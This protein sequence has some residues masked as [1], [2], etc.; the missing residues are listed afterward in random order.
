MKNLTLILILLFY[1][2]PAL[3]AQ[4][5][6][7][8]NFQKNRLTDSIVK[9]DITK[10]KSFF[11]SD[12]AFRYPNYFSIPA[13][14]FI[15]EKIN[16]NNLSQLHHRS[17]FEEIFNPLQIKHSET[18]ILYQ[19]GAN[20]SQNLLLSHF[21]KLNAKNSI[22]SEYNRNKSDGFYLHQN[23]LSEKLVIEFNLK[24]SDSYLLKPFFTYI[25]NT[26]AENGGIKSDS[27]FRE[28]NFGSSTFLETNISDASNSK[29]SFEGGIIQNIKLKYFE[30][31]HR[32][33]YQ[34]I[35]KVFEY[36]VSE[37][38]YDTTL[39]DSSLTTDK[40]KSTI[41]S[42]E[43]SLKYRRQFYIIQPGIQSEYLNYNQNNFDTLSFGNKLFLNSYFSKKHNFLKLQ[44]NYFVNGFNKGNY[45]C[46]FIFEK[47]KLNF[48]TNLKISFFLKNQNPEIYFY[49]MNGNHFHWNNQLN[50]IT[51]LKS[52]IAANS[53]F[54]N[55]KLSF[56][57][58]QKYVFLNENMNVFQSSEKLQQISFNYHFCID[59]K[60]IFW[61]NDFLYQKVFTG[62]SFYRIPE[63]T[64]RSDF[65]FKTKLKAMNLHLGITANYCS[66]YYANAY[67]PAL[68][69][70]YLQNTI[71]TG[72]YP[73]LDFSIYS[74]VK[75]VDIKFTLA[76]FNSGLTGYNYYAT[77]L[78]PI[79]PRSFYFGLSWHFKD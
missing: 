20:N 22:F 3:S 64:L 16:R 67:D 5:D 40:Y 56:E 68:G 48:L 72:N 51:E 8:S 71:K 76:H 66:E 75:T 65:R 78:Y 70:F 42:N 79:A 52:T 63:F 6:T 61:R 41:L 55:F 25:K 11:F 57:T 38:F 33:D 77:P 73:I 17:A 15:T 28:G 45:S 26:R 23:G 60:K 43:I 47:H 46:E 29:Y 27:I 18:F 24:K 36:D 34:T 50:P 9:I 37:N 35:K 39:L 13:S 49:R 19:I 4:T 58:V 74:T 1:L 54:G 14:Q 2:C 21:Q 62:T 30:I 59:K 10:S 69:M 32:I 12:S 31:H 53:K 44:A 7:V